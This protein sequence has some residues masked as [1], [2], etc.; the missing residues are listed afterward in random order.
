V[1]R[2]RGDQVAFAVSWTGIDAPTGGALQV[3]AAGVNGPVSVPLFGAG[4]PGTL[5]AVTGAMTVTDPALLDA[6]RTDPGGSYVHLDTAGYPDGAVRG[7]L[8]TVGHPIDL[9]AVLH[10]GPLTALLDGDQQ[11]SAAGDPDGH[12][13]VFVAARGRR[14]DFSATWS[15]IGAPTDGHLHTGAAGVSGP[16]SVPLFS[17]PSGLPVSINGVAGTVAGLDPA[18][19]KGIN[20]HPAGYYADLHTADF[21]DGAVRGQLFRTGNAGGTA[22]GF[23]FAAGCCPVH[24]S[25]PAPNNPAA[26]S[27]T[28]ST[29]SQPTWRAASSTPSSPTTPAHRNGSHLTAAR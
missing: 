18:V 23:P 4:V 7:Q 26:P 11:V 25:T 20:A 16:V 22:E 10:G 21:P 1:L 19:L 24:R 14:V 2:I 12:A 5:H 6:L 8:H 29:T 28:P 13:G 15:G 9:T 3:G 27:P 17:A